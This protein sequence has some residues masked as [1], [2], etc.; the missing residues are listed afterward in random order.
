MN[1]EMNM[2]GVK[3]NINNRSVEIHNNVTK[4]NILFTIIKTNVLT[5]HMILNTKFKLMI[6]QNNVLNNV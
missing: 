6:S 2:Y 1:V 5:A 3:I 4:K